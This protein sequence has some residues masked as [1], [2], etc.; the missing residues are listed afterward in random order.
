MKKL[1]IV[2]GVIVAVLVVALIVLRV[3]GLDPNERRAGLWLTGEVV[4]P[5]VTD[6]SF[7]DKYRNIYV[8]TK[9]WYLLPHSVTTGAPATDRRLYLT[10]TDRH[11]QQ[12]PGH[13]P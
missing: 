7:T 11:G 6:W 12:G 1:G 8:Q 3:A 10:P 4:T 13:K 5:P 2:V 9:T